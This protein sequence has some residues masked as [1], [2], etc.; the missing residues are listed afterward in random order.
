MA[1]LCAGIVAACVMAVGGA[2]G[3]SPAIL[4]LAYLFL[5]AACFAVACTR[6]G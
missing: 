4:L 1:G 3:L 2:L 5:A 6:Q